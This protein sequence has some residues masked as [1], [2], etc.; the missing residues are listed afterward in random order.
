MWRF[1]VVNTELGIG[2]LLRKSTRKKL[3]HLPS[4]WRNNFYAWQKY[5]IEIQVKIFSIA[6]K[7]CN[8][9][10]FI[11]KIEKLEYEV[12]VLDK[13]DNQFS[14]EINGSREHFFIHGTREKDDTDQ[15]VCCYHH[16]LGSLKGL[17]KKRFSLPELTKDSGNHLSPMPGTVVSIKVKKG[18]KVEKGQVLLLMESMKMEQA[19]IAQQAGSI[20][21]IFVVEGDV[22]EANATLLNLSSCDLHETS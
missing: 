3:S 7:C 18:R 1:Q 13:R 21:D 16:K 14:L 22:V 20:K 15:E 4:G 8:P 2:F 5:S 17:I 19:I 10:K 12:F 9:D 11:Y 6:Y